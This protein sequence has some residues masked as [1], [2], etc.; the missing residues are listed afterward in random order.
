VHVRYGF[1]YLILT[2]HTFAVYRSTVQPFRK[3]WSLKQAHICR[4]NLQQGDR[5]FLLSSIS[6]IFF[7]WARVG[8][9]VRALHLQHPCRQLLVTEHLHGGPA[10]G[11][12]VRAL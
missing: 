11:Q 5:F 12:Q 7:G 2:K 1:L 6:Y 9:G 8:P 4:G 3:G 10:R